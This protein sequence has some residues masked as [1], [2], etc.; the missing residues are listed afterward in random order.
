[1][2]IGKFGIPRRTWD[3]HD[4]EANAGQ[5]IDKNK[6]KHKQIAVESLE[7]D[8]NHENNKISK[9][10]LYQYAEGISVS[11]SKTVERAGQTY[12]DMKKA[13]TEA[14]RGSKLQRYL[15]WK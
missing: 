5:L 14:K 6:N 8:T 2:A 15:I 3:E 9:L 12:R 1:M 7:N 10:K 13:A 4:C 11:N